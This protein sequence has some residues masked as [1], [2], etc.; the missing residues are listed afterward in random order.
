ML[1]TSR[2]YS[3]ERLRTSGEEAE[4]LGRHVQFYLKLAEE[5]DAQFRRSVQE[6][7][8]DRVEKEYENL[9]TA[10][11]WCL[12]TVDSGWWLVDGST[13]SNPDLSSLAL[14]TNHEPL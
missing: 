8:L 10:L 4:L 5:A 7:W 2:G 12:Q 13:E 6:T 3:R 1:E 14:T 11:A 9:R